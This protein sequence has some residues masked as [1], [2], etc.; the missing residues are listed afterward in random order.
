[1]FDRRKNGRQAPA[2]DAEKPFWISFADLMSALMALFLVIMV[3]ALTNVKSEINTD[4]VASQ[5][6][7]LEIRAFLNDID[8]LNQQ[9]FA[10]I[11]V[12][13]NNRTVSFNENAYF[14]Q[15]SD[16]LNEE[17]AEFARRFTKRL[18]GLIDAQQQNWLSKVVV[19]GFTDRTGDYLLNLDLSLRRSQRLLCVLLDQKGQSSVMFSANE[20]ELIKQR[21]FVGGYSSNLQRKSDAESRRIEF[22][23]EFRPLQKIVIDG[24]VKARPLRETGQVESVVQPGP[25]GSCRI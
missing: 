7:E 16:R 18:L 6:R 3:V 13:F 22:R 20:I 19:E 2:D 17:S 11:R 5:Q 8:A 25:T 10:G 4:E 21:F 14:E 9:G 12:D 15:N 24:V 23:M 1:M